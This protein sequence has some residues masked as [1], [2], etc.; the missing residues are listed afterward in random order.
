VTVYNSIYNI[1]H[2][3]YFTTIISEDSAVGVVT[4]PRDEQPGNRGS[5]PDREK[6]HFTFP[7]NL[8]PIWE[9]LLRG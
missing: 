7:E 5:I 3:I 4:T 8:D 2:F 1:S 6:R 9:L